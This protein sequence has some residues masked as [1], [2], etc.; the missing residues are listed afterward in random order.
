MGMLARIFHS[1]GR[2]CA[3]LLVADIGSANG[4]M[5]ALP[6]VVLRPPPGRPQYLVLENL[7]RTP[8]DLAEWKF[9]DGIRFA[10]PPFSTNN[11]AASFLKPLEQVVISAAAEAPTRAAWPELAGRRVF[12]P[13]S[14]RLQPAG[15]RVTLA[16]KNGVPLCSARF[17]EPAPARAD[18]GIVINE[19][20]YDLP[21]GAPGSEYVEL[22]HRG[23][24]SVDLSGWRFTDGIHFDFPAGTRIEPGGFLVIAA[25]AAR[26]RAC[27][28]AIPLAGEY[29]GKL[30]RRGERL[31]LCD[32][33]GQVISEISYGV[34]GDWPAGARGQGRSLELIHPSL[35]PRRALAWQASD[36]VESSEFQQLSVTHLYLE[37]GPEGPVA[38][39]RELHLRLAAR[40][41]VVLRNLRLLHH[42]TNVL[43]Q[44]DRLS[45]DGTGR[46][47]WLAQGTHAGS[48]IAHGELHLVADARGDERGNQVEIDV[49]ALTPRQTYELAGEARWISGTPRL[50]VQTWDRSWSASFTLPIPCRLGTPGRTNSHVPAVPPPVLAHLRHEPVV[51]KPGATVAVSVELQSRVPDS[52]VTLHHRSAGRSWN[53]A[54]MRP[55]GARFVARFPA[56]T[57]N[58]A[59]TEF[60]VEAQGR[61]EVTTLLPRAGVAAPALFVADDRPRE[62]DL[63]LVRIILAPGDL[64]ALSE[65]GPS[66]LS[67]QSLNSTVIWGG[68]N[69]VYGAAARR[70]GSLVSR[71]AGQ[72]KLKLKLPADA[73]FRG[74]TRFVYDDDAA[75]GR[76]YHNRVVRYLLYLLGQ[77]ANE[78]EFVRL[79]V[80]AGPAQ[81]REEVEPVSSEFTTRVFPGGGEGRLYRAEDDWWLADDGD[82]VN[83]EARWI[84]VT[85]V[86]EAGWARRTGKSAE[87]S[88]GLERLLDLLNRRPLPV[89]E[90]TNLLDVD[91]VLALAAVRGFVGDWDTLTM[92]RGHNAF[93]FQRPADGRFQLLHWDSDE[94]FVAGQPFSGPQVEPLLEVPGFRRRFEDH[95]RSLVRGTV[96]QPERFRQ[97]LE[98]ERAATAGRVLLA[99]YPAF[100]ARRSREAA[101]FLHRRPAREFSSSSSGAEP[102]MR[103]Q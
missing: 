7:T 14:G 83:R 95:V 78:N 85:N 55:E 6:E 69:A 80:N 91:A 38:D 89:A 70:S 103:P 49:P 68:T 99:D 36:A 96:G 81:L 39:I 24:T 54:P 42:G 58:G 52:N 21:H 5:V 46:S 76:A 57:T 22:F 84:G 61:G 102:P 90:L 59:V 9:I 79:V 88:A 3:M 16:D 73:P 20:M 34:G 75:E 11:P 94:G 100:F 63:R 77:P 93:L 66:R 32:A 37:S 18:T 45:P 17:E 27:Y 101:E 97:W 31:R 1:G 4:A 48:F 25:S 10:F 65:A 23:N 40:G 19:I 13:W 43:H 2:I 60:Y 47:G 82:G 87:D 53:V 56:G 41:E 86:A 71:E 8:L 62:S 64:A 12:G 51:P 35:D 33:S 29:T 30:S 92:Q 98:Q 50:L 28:G 26:M 44:A 15:E 67:N 72:L 74:R